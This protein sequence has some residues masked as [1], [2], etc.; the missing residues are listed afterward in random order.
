MPAYD[1]VIRSGTVVTASDV[2]P[3]DVAIQGEQI[4]ALGHNLVGK[5][6]I[7]ASGQYV[8][9][10]AIDVH[11]H[12]DYTPYEGMEVLGYPVTTIRR[13]QIIM[14]SGDFVGEKGSGTFLRRQPFR[15][16]L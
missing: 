14:R 12:V 3:S 7:D 4:A 13:G 9:P 8:L 1:L 5:D 10:G 6:S 11:T 16:P 15:W 2:F